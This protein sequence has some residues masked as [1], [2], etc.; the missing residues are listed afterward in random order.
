[1]TTFEVVKLDRRS[2]AGDELWT[3]VRTVDGQSKGGDHHWVRERFAARAMV[4]YERRP[5]LHG[6]RAGD[7]APAFEQE[8]GWE[9]F[10]TDEAYR[11]AV[12]FYSTAD[13]TDIRNWR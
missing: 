10:E 2:I 3:V 13:M 12:D 8:F 5:E 7:L 1:M 4:L 6:A 11:A 9:M